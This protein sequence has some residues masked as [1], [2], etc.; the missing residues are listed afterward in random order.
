MLRHAFP[1]AREFYPD[2]LEKD[3]NSRPVGMFWL[4][5]L[6]TRWGWLILPLMTGASLLISQAWWINVAAKAAMRAR[7]ATSS[8][9]LNWA[10]ALVLLAGFLVLPS[11]L[12]MLFW[13]GHGARGF[14]GNRAKH[15]SQRKQLA[16]VFAHQDGTGP[17]AI[18]RFLNDDGHFADRTAR[19]LAVHRVTPPLDV[20]DENGDYRF[21]SVGK[22]PV[23]ATAITRAVTRARD[24]ELYV[25]LA[26]L[27]EVSGDLAP[28]VAAARV[29][30]ARHHQVLVVVPW[31]ADIPA[32]D[33]DPGGQATD[34]RL[35]LGAV[36]RAG[37]T[38]RYH[39]GYAALKAALGTAGVQVVRVEDGDPVQRVLDR[40]DRLRGTRVR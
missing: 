25:V 6:D 39:R 3:V 20:Y 11:I 12:L 1:V 27:V 4:P 35:K 40:L 22:I 9:W 18:E 16:A 28:L 8:V 10:S 26:D 14:F 37:L 30:R 32:P 15:A 13:V 36:V 29:A 7:P 19:F 21:R 2:L 33:K 5:L 24:N 23:L 38:A 31:P 17:G 34:S